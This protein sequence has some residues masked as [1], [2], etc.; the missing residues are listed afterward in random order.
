MEEVFY[1]KEADKKEWGL[2]SSSE[3]HFLNVTAPPRVAHAGGLRRTPLSMQVVSWPR[4][5]GYSLG[6]SLG[7]RWSWS[8]GV[9]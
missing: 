6:Y 7:D 9:L 4:R 8:P 2:T 1:L 3:T 5:H